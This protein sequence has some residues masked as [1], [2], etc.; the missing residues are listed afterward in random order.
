H[1]LLEETLAVPEGRSFVLDRL[2]TPNTVGVQN[3]GMMRP[4]L[5]ELAP[6][7]LA[8]LMIGGITVADLPDGLSKS[9]MSEA[10]GE[11]EFILPPIPNTLFQRDPSCWIYGGITCNP[12]YWPA[13]KPETLLQ[14]A[15][16]KHHP[17]FS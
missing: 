3:V 14:R 5:D 13:R 12:M 17:S 16:Y 4:W 7:N 10:F 2:I 15:V 8:P 9:M 11:A 6:A 1:D